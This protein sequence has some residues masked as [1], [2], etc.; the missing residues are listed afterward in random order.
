VGDMKKRLF[1]AIA[2]IML[3]LLVTVIYSDLRKRA[4]LSRILRQHDE[5]VSVAHELSSYGFHVKAIEDRMAL[6]E[7]DQLPLIVER[8]VS[9]MGMKDKLQSVKPFGGG[10][11]AE[12]SVQEAEVVME[13]L[14]MNEVVNL[15]YG[16]YTFP[17]GLFATSVEMKRDFSSGNLIDIDMSLKLV[18][19]KEESGK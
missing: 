3:G 16:V 7:K 17:A 4:R 18:S 5:M 1:I 19:P 15:L 2:V 12:Y 8:L 14:T 6:A 10:A 11:E 9:G 13:K